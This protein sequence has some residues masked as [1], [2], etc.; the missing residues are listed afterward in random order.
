MEQLQVSLRQPSV[1]SFVFL[2]DL[3]PNSHLFTT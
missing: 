3:M 1:R 2:K